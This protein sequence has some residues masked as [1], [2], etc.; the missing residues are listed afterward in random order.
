M[1]LGGIDPVKIAE[2]FGL[3]ASYVPNEDGLEEAIAH[4]LR[5]VNEEGRPY[6]LNVQLPLGLPSGG[7]TAQEYVFGKD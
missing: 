1:T 6:L 3:E 4:G 5:V 2:G 7:Q